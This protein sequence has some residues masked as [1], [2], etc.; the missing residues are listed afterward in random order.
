MRTARKRTRKRTLIRRHRR[1]VESKWR[2]NNPNWIKGGA[3]IGAV[4]GATHGGV[5]G[6]HSTLKGKRLPDNI[7]EEELRKIRRHLLSNTVQGVG[8]GGL[9]GAA[10]G[11]FGGNEASQVWN[12]VEYNRRLKAEAVNRTNLNTSKI[13]TLRKKQSQA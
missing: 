1:R 3:A 7:T 6:Y 2:A 5:I 11:A 13:R 8:M 10:V 9:A 4:Y 12:M